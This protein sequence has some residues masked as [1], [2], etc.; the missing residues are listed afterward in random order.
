MARPRRET[1]ISTAGPNALGH[2]FFMYH[3]PDRLHGLALRVR[4]GG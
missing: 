3:L 4:R 2:D 1:P